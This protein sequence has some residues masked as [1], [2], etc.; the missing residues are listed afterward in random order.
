LPT[1]AQRM[2]TQQIARFLTDHPGWSPVLRGVEAS[3]YL[4]V[5]VPGFQSPEGRFVALADVAMMLRSI[6]R[7]ENY[8]QGAK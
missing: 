2:T 1:A 5:R 7:E 3:R 4:I 8:K 6:P